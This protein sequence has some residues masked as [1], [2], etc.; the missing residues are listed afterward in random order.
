M[1]KDNKKLVQ[2]ITS[3]EENFAQWYTDICVKAELVEYSSVKGF[4]ILR[5]YG[6]AI[7]ELIQKD[8]DARFKATGHENVA[9]PV[10]MPESLLKKEGELVNG[11][12]PEVAWVTM[13][14]SEKL[15]ERLA[16]RPTSETLFCDHWSR[17]LHSYRELPMKYN[18]WCSVIR[19]EKTTRPFLRSREF[20]WQEGHTIHET[21]AEAEAETQQQLNCYAD[22]CEQDLAIPVVKGRKTDKEKFAGAEATYTIEAMMKDGKALQSGTS[23]Y[24]GDKFSKAYDVTFTGRD[25]QLH[26][27]FQTSWG[28]STRLVGAIIMTHGDDDGL[29]LPPAVAPIQ[30]VVVPIA[31]HKPGVSEKAAELAEKMRRGMRES[32]LKGQAISRCRALGLKTDEHKR[33]VIDEKTAPTVRFIF[34][35]YAA[36]ESAMSIVEQLNAKGLRTSQ[37]NPFNKSSIPRIIQNE[38]YRGVYISKSYDVRIEGAIPAI[39]D[40]EL[41][42]RAQTMLKLN[43]QL[44]AKN[45]PK[46]DYILSGK[47]YCSCG[48]LMRGMSGHSAT[49]EVYRYYTCPNKDCHLRNIPKDDLEGKVMQS[50]VDHLL[51]P[52][53]ME[54]LAEAMVEVQKA[55]AEKPN[56][57][58]VAIEQSL[59]DVRRR[60]KNILDAIENGT[61]NA[62]LCARLNDLTEQEQTLSFQLSSLEKEKPVA[63]TKEQYLFLLEQFL[64]EPSERTPEYGRRLVNTFVTSMVV[65]DR[66]LV[67]N[68]NVSDETVNKNKKASQ[69]NLQKESSS[70][71]RLVR[72]ARIELTAS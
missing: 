25:N 3:Q 5:P 53:S 41:W 64:V 65:S 16:V 69:T 15:E 49:G 38:A 6:Q 4:I 52:E 61:A 32:A 45:E 26:H 63:F 72:V 57:E 42:E 36:G 55:D 43:R 35:H 60:S 18:Q 44:K 27:P 11:F 9:M 10:L 14:G 37:G 12:A 56:A 1:A 68:F 71:M 46:A 30:V 7:W 54:A 51:Q 8:L 17:V 66:E 23:H 48:S 29:I 13:G 20:W 19:W 39:I 59:A 34:E 24:F 58:R 67:I 70:G 21:A 28:V 33:F 31:A 22:V 40:D 62:Q 50:I 2:A 47:L